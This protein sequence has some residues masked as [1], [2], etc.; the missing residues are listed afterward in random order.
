MLLPTQESKSKRDS[1]LLRPPAF[2]DRLYPCRPLPPGSHPNPR[3]T[4]SQT[5]SMEGF[6][7]VLPRCADRTS[8]TSIESPRARRIKV[9]CHTPARIG[10]FS[11]DALFVVSRLHRRTSCRCG[12]HYEVANARTSL[13]DRSACYQQRYSSTSRPQRAHLLPQYPGFLDSSCDASVRH[14]QTSGLAVGRNGQFRPQIW[15]C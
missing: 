6:H 15:R 5:T 2:A 10:P 11:E 14:S 7:R 13:N 9:I 3:S 1:K 8:L 4:R 12:V